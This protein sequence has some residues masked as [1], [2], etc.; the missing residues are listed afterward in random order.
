MKKLILVFVLSLSSFSYADLFCT[1]GRGESQVSLY[2][3]CDN[4]SNVVL[5]Y[6]RLNESE[7]CN[8]KKLTKGV[9]L[10]FANYEC[11]NQNGDNFAFSLLKI[12]SEK[13]IVADYYGPLT[14]HFNCKA[15]G[16]NN[17][18]NNAITES[19]KE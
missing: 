7:N 17:C 2:V 4:A 11:L 6:S 9:D 16:S 10:E 3:T 1:D 12:D 8:L 14:H 18:F 13:Q 19:E 15:I 5:K